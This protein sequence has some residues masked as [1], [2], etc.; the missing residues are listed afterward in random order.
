MSLLIILLCVISLKI[1]LNV[2]RL[3]STWYCFY[4]FKKQP[5]NINELA[6]LVTSLF[7]NAGTQVS[8]ISTVRSNS[9]NCGYPDYISNCLN[10]KNSYY[11]IQDIF[12]KTIGVYKLRILQS[13]NI[14]YYLFLPKHILE[15]FGKSVSTIRG[16]IINIIYWIVSIL[17]AYIIETLLD[18]YF[19]QSLLDVINNLLNNIIQ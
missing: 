19:K 15:H 1:I 7:N 3:I 13:I 9:L 5:K 16:I 18:V 14:F 8:V 4:K 2:G 12:Y 11:S 10:K 6:P 17:S